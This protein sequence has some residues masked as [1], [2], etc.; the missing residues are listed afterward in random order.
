MN[1]FDGIIEASRLADMSN[2]KQST[3]IADYYV[4]NVR[5][6]PSKL[7]SMTYGLQLDRLTDAPPTDLIDTESSLK[8][9]FDLLGRSGYVYRKEKESVYPSNNDSLLMTP[10]ASSKTLPSSEKL[11]T[12]FTPISG[13]DFSS[14]SKKSCNNDIATSRQDINLTVTPVPKRFDYIDTRSLTKDKLQ[15]CKQ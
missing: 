7:P 11:D 12:F 3:T 2:T 5:V 13:R 4:N 8:N 10:L 9:Q 6:T 15:S 1:K 14:F